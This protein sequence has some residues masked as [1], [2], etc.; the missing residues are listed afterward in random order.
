MKIIVN[1]L[2]EQYSA[3]LNCLKNNVLI[4]TFDMRKAIIAS[5]NQFDELAELIEKSEGIINLNSREKELAMTALL[6]SMERRKKFFSNDG[7]HCAFI[8]ISVSNQLRAEIRTLNHELNQ[9]NE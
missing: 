9:L 4:I 5:A 7:T 6:G 8:P 1:A 2:R 3:G